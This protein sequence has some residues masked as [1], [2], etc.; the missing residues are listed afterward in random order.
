MRNSPVRIKPYGCVA[1]LA[2]VGALGAGPV[3][4][5]A[6][7]L[8]AAQ[9]DSLRAELE[10]L[11]ARLDSLAGVVARGQVAPEAEDLE[12]TTTDAIARLRAAAEAAA[13]DAATDTVA[14]GSPEFV[15][16]AR[17]LQALNPEISLN[18]DLFGSIHSDDPG[19][20]NFVP[21]EF[22]FAFVSALDPYTRA[23]VVFSVE[24]G[25]ARIE[26]FPEDQQEESDEVEIG[27]EEGHVEW[28]ALPG[29]IGLKIGRFFQQFG[30]LNRWHSHALQFQSRSLPHLAFIGEGALAQDGASVHWLLPTGGS[31][32][33]EA[34]VEVTRSRNETLFGESHRLSYL[35]H[36]NA[37]LQLS[38][39][40][41]LDLGVCA[42]FGDYEDVAGRRSQR[43]FGAEMSFNWA[44]PERSLYRGVVVRG[45]MMLS[46][47]GV[48]SGLPE[49][50]A[51]WGIWSLAE[52]KLS[53]SWIAG[54]R[55]EWV[56]N[57]EDPAESAWLVSPTL[58]YWQ[59]E[60]VRLRV[61]YDVLGNP[62]N[63]TGQFTL[64]VTFAMGPHKHE[65][66]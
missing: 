17:S 59:S 19:S 51:A 46:D 43:L 56:E 16:R 47:P 15:G 37:F 8:P 65:T 42:L 12:E 21:R 30:Q 58:T 45:G 6:Q 41:D 33:Y 14:Q 50:D 23:K 64:R 24:E 49:L 10:M 40:T 11:R 54:G 36:L 61:E 1:F 9:I 13:G 62:G 2:L 5:H 48:V 20:E 52:V 4:A 28:V 22:E 53:R 66:Y 35:G 32:A 39:S 18:V 55:Y 7:D 31:V 60:Y 27:V 26:V 25:G 34:T 38:A 29:G 63:T 57:P 44:P 3:L